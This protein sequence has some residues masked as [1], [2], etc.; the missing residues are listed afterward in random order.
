[1][2]LSGLTFSRVHRRALLAVLTLFLVLPLASVRAQSNEVAGTMPEDYLPELKEILKTALQRNPDVI[3]RDF[4]R[5]VYEAKITQV[6]A[7][8]LPQLG[9]SFNY[10]IT[11][12]STTT[13]NSLRE[14]ND[15]F[16]YNF[17]FSQAI[18]HWGALKNQTASARLNLLI[19]EKSFALA[20]RELSVLLRKIYLALIV[21]RA[22]L[23]QIRESHQVVVSDLAIAEAKMETGM[24]ASSALDGERVRKREVE[25]ELNRAEAEFA[26]SRRRFARLA[27]LGEL[28]EEKIPT[29]IPRPAYS[30]P[31]ATAMVASV[32]RDN[33]RSTLEF[34]IYDLRVRDALLQ[35]KIHGTR[36]LPKIGLSAAYS[37][38]NTTNVNG[39]LAQQKAV[40]QQSIA[41][42]G[43]WSIFDG[44]ATRG[45][46]REVLLLR[47]AAEHQKASKIEELL[48]NVQALERTLKMDAEQL[49]LSDIRHSAAEGGYERVQS[50]VRFGNLPKGTIDR[51]RLGVLLA[52]ARSFESRAAFLGRWS[53]LVAMS[54]ADPV[55]DNLPARYVRAKK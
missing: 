7:Q 46:K 8:R 53:E 28:P 49:E 5:L 48:Q 34:E 2:V 18:F 52:Q 47:R 19:S 45:V 3:A 50:E 32:L 25:L 4:E 31:G 51:A 54:G 55:L 37:L 41:L 22:R 35:Q 33:A 15:G 39:D 14:K 29:E 20:Y 38:T 10:G 43:T 24:I 13:E 36:L 17:G 12:T 16:F 1:M 27:G 30:E 42:G 11:E 6:S 26:S 21:E 40:A 9:G 23:R 44:F